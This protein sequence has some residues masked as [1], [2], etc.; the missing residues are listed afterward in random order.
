MGNQSRRDVTAFRR[1][2]VQGA[3]LGGCL[4]IP[5]M[6]MMKMVIQQIDVG[7]LR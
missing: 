1:D 6:Q 3:G 5:S 2:L 4:K 7:G